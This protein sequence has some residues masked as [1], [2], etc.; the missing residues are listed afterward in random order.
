[1][2]PHS[3]LFG[4]RKF[5]ANIVGEMP[6]YAH[7]V[8]IAD[9]IRQR[10]PEMDTAFCVDIWPVGTPYLMVIKPDLMYQLTQANQLP[11]G[12]GLQPFLKPLA[13]KQNL[14]TMEGPTWKRWRSIFSPGFSVSHISSLVPG[15]V[16]KVETF[17]RKL[18]DYADA[19]ELFYLEEM[20]LNL[21]IDIIGGAVMYVCHVSE[22]MLS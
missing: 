10:F 11:K 16:E 13:G 20:A 18:R 7:G 12:P 19:G 14:V 22:S 15:I 2:P 8:Y 5:V 6:P 3:F 21:T 17:G 4:H 9:K 1:M